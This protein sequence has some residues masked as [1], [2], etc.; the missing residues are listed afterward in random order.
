MAVIVIGETHAICVFA[1]NF[2]DVFCENRPAGWGD[3]LEVK[4]SS[5]IVPEATIRSSKCS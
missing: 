3:R 5:S 2:R 4:S 1:W